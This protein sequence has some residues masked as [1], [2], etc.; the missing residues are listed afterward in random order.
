MTL[1]TS[2]VNDNPPRHKHYYKDKHNHNTHNDNTTTTHTAQ[3]QP[4]YIHSTNAYTAHTPTHRIHH[5][6]PHDEALAAKPRRGCSL[7]ARDGL[8]PLGVMC[9]HIYML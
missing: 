8:L 9:M 5:I 4:L 1:R 3:T 2:R 7:A 6:T